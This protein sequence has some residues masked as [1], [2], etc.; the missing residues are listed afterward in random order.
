MGAANSPRPG[1]LIRTCGPNDLEV[2]LA[3]GRQTFYDTFHA[4]NTPEN[5][6][7]YL[8]ASFAP[9]R[10]A[11]ELADPGIQYFFLYLGAALA[12]Y[13]KLNKPG[14]QTDDQSPDSLEIERIYV[15][16]DFQ[17]R[18]L[19]RVLVDKALEVARQEGLK[20][21]WL[22]VWQENTAA[23]G[24][25]RRMGFRAFATHSFYLGDEHQTDDLMRIEI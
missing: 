24:F 3:L 20:S 7:A 16:R 5:M 9:E 1:L 8:D 15:Q 14:C 4:M 11:A 21:V 17:G 22:G 23:I 12:G 6:Q 2:L 10:I 25:Y 19:G 18:G 13:I